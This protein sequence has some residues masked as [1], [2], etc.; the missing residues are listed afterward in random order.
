MTGWEERRQ[1]KARAARERSRGTGRGER[2]Q[3][4]AVLSAMLAQ[5]TVC[6]ILLALAWC[7]KLSGL[8]FYESARQ[9]AGEVLGRELNLGFVDAMLAQWNLQLPVWSPEESPAQPESLPA[10]SSSEQ[11]EL[12]E[13]EVSA[14]GIIDE[15]LAGYIEQYLPQPHAED[16]LKDEGSGP[17][18][19]QQPP[20]EL[21]ID[22]APQAQTG[23]GGGINP[24]RLIRS[25]KKV[26]APDSA[27]LAPFFITDKPCLPVARGTL[28][29]R[30]GYR[31]HPITGKDDFHTGVDIAAAGGTPISAVLPGTV[32]E[33]GSSAIY[34]KY[35]VIRH[36]KTLETA[37]C[38]CSEILAPEGANVRKREVIAKV[39]STGMSTGNHVHLEFRVNGLQANPA[40]VYDEF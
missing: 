28:T 6:L 10:S 38:H 35:I 29:C 17:S 25:E 33:V 26:S 15:E 34:G 39:G 3:Q 16:E 23:Q 31:I 9:A 8:P 14:G 22:P 18:D 20:G 32:S 2:L 11:I 7:I 40:W 4:D 5:I 30:F 24:I 27:T 21:S 13:E 37:Y 19:E 1:T 12:P 36:S